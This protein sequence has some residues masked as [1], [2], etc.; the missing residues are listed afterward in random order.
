MQAFDLEP[1]HGP[2]KLA[3]VVPFFQEVS[4]P[5]RVVAVMEGLVKEGL[6]TRREASVLEE[7]ML[8]CVTAQGAWF[9]DV[10]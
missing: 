9:W 7:K 6:L 3:A 1:P 5:P 8:L 10:S 4:P 2:D